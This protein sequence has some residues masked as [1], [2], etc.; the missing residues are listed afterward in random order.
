MDMRSKAVLNRVIGKKNF[1]NNKQFGIRGI[2]YVVEDF[3][4]LS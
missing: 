3:F 4:S 2:N 1:T